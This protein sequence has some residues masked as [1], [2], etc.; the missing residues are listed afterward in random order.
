[1]PTA[2]K[3]RCLLPVADVL[4]AL[5]ESTGRSGAF[6]HTTTSGVPPWQRNISTSE[7]IASIANTTD[8]NCRY[9]AGA[10]ASD[11]KV[12]SPLVELTSYFAS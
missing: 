10:H 6:L 11:N 3:I 7:Q 9:C 12:V 2:R 4:V 8:D 1:M 5:G